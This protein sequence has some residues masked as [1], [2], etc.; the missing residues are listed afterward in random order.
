MVWTSKGKKVIHMEMEK[1]MFA[2]QMFI[3]LSLRIGFRND[4][5]KGLC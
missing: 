5:A 4:W 1:Q 3:G 2:K